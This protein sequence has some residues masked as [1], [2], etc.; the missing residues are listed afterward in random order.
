MKMRYKFTA[1]FLMV[2]MIL[3]L[4]VS[5][6]KQQPEEASTSDV[7]ADSV[8][9]D[10][11]RLLEVPDVNFDGYEFSFFTGSHVDT[12]PYLFTVDNDADEIDRAIE[13]RNAE[14]EDKYGIVI[15]EVREIVED[16]HGNGAAFKAL[17]KAWNANEV[18]YD[19]AVGSPYDCCA[20]SQGGMLSDLRDYGY[21]NLEKAWWDQPANEAFTVYG[22]TFITTGDINYIDDNFTY[23]IAFNKNMIDVFDLEDPYG[24]VRE[25][26]WTYDKLYEMS[27]KVTKL[28]NIDGY[29][30][31]DIYGA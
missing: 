17:Q 1:L 7:T 20:L 9:E 19:A 18:L 27:K 14:I 24:I 11:S 4:A 13:K 26:V 30:E 23:A 5:C 2:C 10:T 25:G 6:N 22:K 3:P 15:T 12:C 31:G 29:S 28:D 8:S 21:I 16:A